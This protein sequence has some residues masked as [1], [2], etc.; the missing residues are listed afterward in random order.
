MKIKS[1]FLFLSGL[2]LLSSC[3][4][5]GITA[6]ENWQY[7]FMVEVHSGENGFADKL[8]ELELDLNEKLGECYAGGK[9]VEYRSIRVFELDSNGSPVKECLCQYD[10]NMLY[11]MME[12]KTP[13]N[14][15]RCYEVYFHT[16]DQHQIEDELKPQVLKEDCSDG[17]KF[18]TTEGYYVFERKGGAYR[19][20]SPV[21]CLD[22]E[23]G[24]DWIRD[25]YSGYNGILNIG[26]PETHAIFH[27][28]EDKE[29]GEGIW[30]GC[31]SDIVFS[32]PLHY[33]IRSINNFGD[34][35][36]DYRSNTSYVVVHDI[37]P[38]FIRASVSRGNASGIACIMEM[39][40]GGDSLE[41]YDYVI[42]SDG[43][44]YHMDEKWYE[45]ISPEWL[46]V[47]D[48]QDSVRLFF[49]HQDDD[50]V[51]DGL[52]WYE[53][54]QAV[55]VGW[56]R[57]A[58]P[59]MHRYPCIF[60]MGFSKA[61]NFQDMKNWVASLTTNPEVRI[62]RTE[63]NNN[64]PWG[65]IHIEKKE[66]NLQVELENSKLHCRYAQVQTANTETCMT[67]L[68]IKEV[69]QDQVDQFVDEM[70]AWS[71]HDRG[72]LSD[73]TGIIYQG[74]DRQTVH[75]EWDSGASIEEVTIF[76]DEPYLKIDYLKMYVNICDIGAPGGIKN[77]NH[78]IYGAEEWQKMRQEMLADPAFK[79]D[80]NE[81]HQL[82]ADLYPEYP[83]PLLGDWGVA[84]ENNP[85]NYNGWYIL[86]V[87]NPENGQGYGRVIP[88]D[89]IDHLK[90][91]WGKGFEQFPF[92]FQKKA[93]QTFTE[94]LFVVTMG[95]REI[96]SLGKKIA[97]MANA[98]PWYVVDLV[99][100]RLSNSLI[101]I[102]YG[103][104]KIVENNRLSGYSTFLFKPEN[105][106]FSDKMDAFGYDYARYITGGPTGYEIT[107]T[108]PRYI[109][110]SVEMASGE[111]H[112]V[113]K[114]ERIFRGL[115]VVEIEYSKLDILWWEDFYDHAGKA[116][117]SY[118]IYGIDHDITAAK[119]AE[120]RKKAERACGHNY[121]DCFLEAAGSSVQRS[122]YKGYLIFGFH[123]H[124][125]GTGLGFIIPS[126]ID[127]HDGF[128]LW[129]MHN[130]ESFPF[131]HE[132]KKLPLKRWIY[133]SE[134]GREGILSR[135]MA[136]VDFISEGKDLRTD[137]LALAE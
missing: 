84:G 9:P 93:D 48:R 38:N 89:A 39:T 74:K 51:T 91:L 107:H 19:I 92:W 15:K 57:N 94:Y 114:K 77:G 71:G 12:G 109:E 105:R 8:I 106:N 78:A 10:I 46:F 52:D 129:S 4:G 65:A 43:S 3:A 90:L 97:D 55:M 127:L 1:I 118:T 50:S 67:E 79:N 101:S 95:A 54:M 31:K 121:G 27:P 132:E 34:I 20:F 125:T 61:G 24:K 136:L 111:N 17:W 115:P 108:G 112:G 53:F 66:G 25:D 58:N 130:Y 11:W 18:E 36:R 102:G 104:D 120:Y 119:Q 85:M 134:N 35:G 87:Y 86:G 60:Y 98:S 33:R 21:P 26:D 7:R 81:H 45:D 28:G 76:P 75:L 68:L 123:D 82:T 37:Y 131:L 49:I 124:G 73:K 23:N 110:A 116:D 137:P 16:T 83:H 29:A 6:P 88:V 32:G 128:K 62:N 117:R 100:H 22:N 13:V 135:G 69:H 122:T 30:N 63:Q 99:D 41:P 72:V 70:A 14:S 113:E 2:L 80:T 96:I 40:P 59:G 56:G 133:V 47:G 44:V 42:R 126:V 5:P 103:N 64:I